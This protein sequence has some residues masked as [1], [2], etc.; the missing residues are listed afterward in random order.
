MLYL[1]VEGLLGEI[2][3]K[4]E[5]AV[6]FIIFPPAILIAPDALLAEIDSHHILQPG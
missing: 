3:D 4:S 5:E 2:L 6:G 1:I